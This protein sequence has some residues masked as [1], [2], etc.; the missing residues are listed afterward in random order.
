VNAFFKSYLFSGNHH[1]KAL[2]VLF[3]SSTFQPNLI[4]PIS[5]ALYSAIGTFIVVGCF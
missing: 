1:R 2:V 5:I 4:S 3:L